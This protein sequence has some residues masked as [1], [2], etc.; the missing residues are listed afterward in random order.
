MHAEVG[1]QGPQGL[2]DRR[3]GQGAVADRYAATGQH[4]G[5]VAGAAYL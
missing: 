3:I 1:D 2:H 5:L 4:S